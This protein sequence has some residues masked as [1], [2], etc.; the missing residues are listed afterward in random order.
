M[1][2]LYSVNVYAFLPMALFYNEKLLK[3]DMHEDR[4]FK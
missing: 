1:A 3:I 2:V 4:V